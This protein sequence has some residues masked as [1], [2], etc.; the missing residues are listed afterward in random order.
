MYNHKYTIV[1][2]LPS[3]IVQLY[4]CIAVLLLIWIKIFFKT[5]IN[6]DMDNNILYYDLI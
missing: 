2:D 4:N 3:A 1:I 6:N 5:K